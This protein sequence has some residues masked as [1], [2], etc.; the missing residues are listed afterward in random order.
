[1]ILDLEKDEEG[2]E[3]FPINEMRGGRRW[4]W[5]Y[6]KF[7]KTIN[8]EVSLEARYGFAMLSLFY[9]LINNTVSTLCFL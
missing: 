9:A 8:S 1:L 6:G 3:W 2:M 5:N 7:W 4:F